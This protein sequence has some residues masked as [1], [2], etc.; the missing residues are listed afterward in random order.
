[1]RVDF[2]IIPSAEANTRLRFACQLAHTV[3]RQGQRL[4]I[5]T[6]SPMQTR[7][8]DQLLWTFRDDSFI[9]HDIY[10]D[11]SDNIAP[12]RLGHSPATCPET[13]VLLNL[14]YQIPAFYTQYARILEIVTDE[15]QIRELTRQHYRFYHTHGCELHTHNI[16]I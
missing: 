4:Y 5:Y 3:L 1:M 15:T 8:L 16:S 2:Y 10:P 6:D 9:A 11:E 12:V 13:D 7:F 14:A